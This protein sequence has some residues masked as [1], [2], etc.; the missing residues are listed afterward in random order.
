MEL[1]LLLA[2]DDPRFGQIVRGKLD[3]DFIAR[4]DPNEMFPHLARD[5]RQHIALTGEID[6]K[7]CPRQ[8]LGHRSLHHDLF[9]LR[10]GAE[11]YQRTFFA[12]PNQ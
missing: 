11:I 3:R 2:K 1:P 10:H 9:F 6:P 7:H 12:Q 8:Y 5:V 4:D